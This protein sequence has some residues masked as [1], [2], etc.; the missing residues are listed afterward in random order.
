MS[1]WISVKD[2]LPKFNTKVRVYDPTS[3]FDKERED[4]MHPEKDWE[5][6]CR[7][8]KGRTYITHWM[9]L[10]ERKKETDHATN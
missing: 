10:S 9:P 4:F 8:T 6:E 3:W 7:R 2:R 5:S 1:D